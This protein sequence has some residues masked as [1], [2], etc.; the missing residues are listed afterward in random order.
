MNR[1]EDER[2]K[3][4]IRFRDL[5]VA[6]IFPSEDVGEI[7]VVPHRF[8]ICCLMFLAEMTAARFI[9]GERVTTHQLAELEEISDPS[10]PLE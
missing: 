7:F 10:S 1:F 9:A 2:F 4:Q 5:P 6:L 3:M 8:A